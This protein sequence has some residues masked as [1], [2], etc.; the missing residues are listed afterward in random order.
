MPHKLCE[1]RQMHYCDKAGKLPTGLEEIP[2][3]LYLL[4]SESDMKHCKMY[5]T[6]QTQNHNYKGLTIVY[7]W[8]ERKEWNEKGVWD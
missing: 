8:I 5:I 2:F 1:I 6:K 7:Q 3:W 4:P